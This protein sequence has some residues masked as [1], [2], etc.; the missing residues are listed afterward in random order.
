MKI[1]VSIVEEGR[2]YK[3]LR[4]GMADEAAVTQLLEDF[5]EFLL[6]NFGELEEGI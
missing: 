2:V 4:L 5:E 1:I 3:S 6:T